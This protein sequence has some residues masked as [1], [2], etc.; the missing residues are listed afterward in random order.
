MTDRKLCLPVA[1]AGILVLLVGLLAFV[2]LARYLY[3]AEKTTVWVLVLVWILILGAELQ[4][5]IWQWQGIWDGLQMP[6][7]EGK[8]TLTPY[9]IWG[10]MFLGNSWATVMSWQAMERERKVRDEVASMDFIRQIV[11][12]GLSSMELLLDGQNEP[13]L[14]SEL[15]RGLTESGQMDQVWIGF[16]DQTPEK[17]ILV[18][19]SWA[20]PDN[21]LTSEELSWERL[22]ARLPAGQVFQ[23]GRPV[24][25]DKISREYRYAA[26]M[27]MCRAQGY[28][29]MAAI[30]VRFKKRVH[31]VLNLYSRRRNFFTPG[32]LMVLES[33]AE[34]IGRELLFFRWQQERRNL[35]RE[36]QVN[37]FYLSEASRITGL[38]Y[39]VW[40]LQN[41]STFWSDQL[42]QIHGLRAG[43]F[44]PGWEGR[45][46]YLKRVHPTDREKVG[47]VLFE[48]I[49]ER[50]SS[51]LIWRILTP[52]KE[53]RWLQGALRITRRGGRPILVRGVVVDVTESK[54]REEMYRALVYQAPAAI[55]L[56]DPHLVIRTANPFAENLLGRD[57][58]EFTGVHFNQLLA[59]GET[60]Q[61][62]DPLKL[63]EG[64]P[65]PLEKKLKGPGG[66]PFTAEV[67]LSKLAD[68]Q[69]MIVARDISRV[70]RERDTF[71]RW[72]A[73]LEARVTERTQE[74]E[75]ALQDLESFAYTVS[76][77]LRAPIRRIA[78]FGQI[79]LQEEDSRALP[80]DIRNY[81]H[82]MTDSAREMGRLVEDILALS[83]ISRTEIHRCGVNISML[84]HSVLEQLAEQFPDRVVQW[85]VEPGLVVPADPGLAQILVRNLLE[86][87]WKY[88]D[89]EDRKSAIRVYGREAESGPGQPAGRVIVFEDN[90]IGFAPRFLEKIFQPFQRLHSGEEFGGT[91]VGLAT[92]RKIMERHGGEI[93]ARSEPG[94]GARFFIQFP[95]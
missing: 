77:D 26:H 58:G 25:V 1:I 28:Q 54:S 13:R 43:Q 93:W 78:G 22:P 60:N 75:V 70:A 11:A 4:F 16:R 87:A 21:F 64:R 73:E 41:D 61:L 38:G 95:V 46:G 23:N 55:F 66:D 7:L 6:G 59:G 9:L 82:R 40:D 3:L 86:N 88:S 37:K 48:D 45:S 31:A 39:W 20:M 63:E 84:A 14:L 81:V 69:I 15:C 32:R 50:E 65:Q 53:V 34:I 36:Y 79:L 27:E 12:T 5:F 35:K 52:D 92:A 44:D 80:A 49:R 24:V 47:R 19:G 42:F 91:G 89:Q 90:G 29:S 74:L 71:E 30:P 56:T 62:I 8:L 57:S 33:L 68:G 10:L 18:L 17:R 51:R 83:R 67:T 76:H 94:Q 72:N 85:N 2:F